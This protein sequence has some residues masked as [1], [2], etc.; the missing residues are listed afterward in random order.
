MG[1]ITRSVSIG[2]DAAVLGLTLWKTIY[3]FKLDKEARQGKTL[4][5][6]LAYN[7]SAILVLWIIKINS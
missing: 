4:T 3:F 7:G 1:V 6:T 2:A 5:S